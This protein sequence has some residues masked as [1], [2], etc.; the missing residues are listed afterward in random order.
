MIAPERMDS[1]GSRKAAEKCGYIFEG[2]LRTAIFSRG[3]YRDINM[4]A[5]T[6]QEFEKRKAEK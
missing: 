6:R 4:L 3:E 1:S 2:T 5:I